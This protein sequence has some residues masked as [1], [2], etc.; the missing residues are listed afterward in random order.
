VEHITSIQQSSSNNQI[1]NVDL[2]GGQSRQS[3]GGSLSSYGTNIKDEDFIERLEKFSIEDIVEIKISRFLDQVGC[4][5]LENM[6]ELIMSKVEKPLILQILRRVG[7]NQV[8]AAKVLGI[9]RNTLRK[10]IK[11][12]GL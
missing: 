11:L 5:Q 8:Q 6:H 7:G 2:V 10:K 1:D 12:Y 9:N 3:M 4:I